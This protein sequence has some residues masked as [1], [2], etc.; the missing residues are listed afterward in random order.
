[1]VASRRRPKDGRELEVAWHVVV[2]LRAHEPEARAGATVEIDGPSPLRLDMTGAFS[3][4]PYPATAA[5]MVQT[6]LALRS[7]PPELLTVAEVP[8]GARPS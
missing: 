4:D 5:R 1:V 6:A 8:L 2:D 3:A 7:L